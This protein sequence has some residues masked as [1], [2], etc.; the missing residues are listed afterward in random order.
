MR[1]TP[2]SAGCPQTHKSDS[3]TAGS[4]RGVAGFARGASGAQRSN[5]SAFSPSLS[6]RR[7]RTL[8]QR[9]SQA[10]AS[11]S[12]RNNSGVV[13]VHTT[14]TTLEGRTINQTAAP[15]LHPRTL[16]PSPF[17][18]F[19]Q[20]LQKE[21]R[22]D[23]VLIV[24]GRAETADEDCRTTQCKQQQQQRRLGPP[25]YTA[26]Q[27]VPVKL[28]HH[29]FMR[30]SL[31]ALK[32]RLVPP[33]RSSSSHLSSAAPPARLTPPPS[34]TVGV[35][36]RPPHRRHGPSAVVERAPPLPSATSSATSSTTST[37]IKSSANPRDVCS[38]YN[39][40]IR[41]AA[42][43]ERVRAEVLLGGGAGR[44][45][46]RRKGRAGAPATSSASGGRVGGNGS[47]S[48]RSAASLQQRGAGGGSTPLPPIASSG[49]QRGDDDCLV[50]SQ[51][52]DGSPRLAPLVS[53]QHIRFQLLLEY[54]VD[55]DAHLNNGDNDLCSGD[56]TAGLTEEE[57]YNQMGKPSGMAQDC[58]IM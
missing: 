32:D 14:T 15:S 6:S 2:S 1:R 5:S 12:G 26:R 19:Q 39:F 55:V 11:T 58:S 24:Y 18:A 31:G 54:G 35:G 46:E 23:Y 4:R 7:G 56:L 16:L 25:A 29:A 50:D 49:R 34:S 38:L 53:A 51:P 47:C 20:Q 40:L 22:C 21:M 9:S 44:G 3:A 45:V 37:A 13:P 33:P 27:T 52:S 36:A 41:Y 43:M 30:M 10:S 17:L 28:A 48:V 8:P 42:E 57:F